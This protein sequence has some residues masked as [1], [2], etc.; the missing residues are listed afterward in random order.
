MC[1]PSGRACAPVYAPQDDEAVKIWFQNRRSKY[2]KMMKAAQQSGGGGGGQHGSLL[3]TIPS[4]R[5]TWK[6]YAR[7]RT[8]LH[9]QQR[10]AAASRR[11]GN[12]VVRFRRGE[13][14]KVWQG[15]P[16]L[17]RRR[18]I[19]PTASYVVFRRDKK[20]QTK[21]PAFTE[22]AGPAAPSL[23]RVHVASFLQQ[24]NENSI[25]ISE[26]L[27]RKKY[28][29]YIC[30]SFTR[31]WPVRHERATSRSINN[32]TPNADRREGAPPLARVMPCRDRPVE[33]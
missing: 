18:S 30:C 15:R 13:P 27:E 5:S 14:G 33:C 16:G 24:E 20:H 25:N 12:G 26:Y 2:K 23:E 19:H 17:G 10:D 6:S 21:P 8:Q 7:R 31:I 3:A 22:S 4:T 32:V 28:T 29:L 9:V 1:N 11:R